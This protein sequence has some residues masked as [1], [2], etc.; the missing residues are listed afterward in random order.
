MTVRGSALDNPGRGCTLLCPRK[1]L[2]PLTLFAIDLNDIIYY[3]R[4][5]LRRYARLCFELDMV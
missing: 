3:A 4:V 2:H 1:G 5:L